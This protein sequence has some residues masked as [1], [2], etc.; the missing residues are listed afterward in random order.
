VT[1]DDERSWLRP[2]VAAASRSIRPQ[3][4]H[5]RTLRSRGP[6]YC[7]GVVTLLAW[8]AVGVL[9]GVMPVF[10]LVGIV[11]FGD[12]AAV[13]LCVGLFVSIAW[14]SARYRAKRFPERTRA[15]F[16]QSQFGVA[17]LTLLA[18]AFAAHVVADTW[19]AA[20]AS[21]PGFAGVVAPDALRR[22][23]WL[24]KIAAAADAARHGVHIGMGIAVAAA[25]VLAIV[26]KCLRL[27]RADVE[28][29]PVLFA[30]IYGLLILP[31]LA[32]A[33]VEFAAHTFAALPANAGQ[34]SP[35]A[36]REQAAF[37]LA[38]MIVL[39]ASWAVAAMMVGVVAWRVSGGQVRWAADTDPGPS[40][41]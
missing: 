15:A 8:A 33:T 41:V 2:S 7:V 17:T 40:S 32:F 39:A 19:P 28:R 21:L 30:P 12:A 36:F 34:Y 16:W 5:R 25:V 26:A 38:V 10:W 27:T 9:T 22:L 20:V 6:F 11:Y 1:R 35:A 24:P 31:F 37:C 14:L 29:R 3:A 18:L 13:L 23:V 4:Q